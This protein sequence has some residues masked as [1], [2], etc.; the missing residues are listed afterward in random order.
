M[1]KMANFLNRKVLNP[2]KAHLWEESVLLFVCPVSM[3]IM[4]CGR[5][6]KGY[7]IKLPTE[8]LKKIVPALKWGMFFLKA[9]LASQGLG[10][11]A[12]D[13]A[14]LLPIIDDDYI[15]NIEKAIVSCVQPDLEKNIDSLN[16]FDQIFNEILDSTTDEQDQAAFTFLADFLMK[17]EKYQGTNI[18]EWEPKYT[19]LHKAVSDFDGSCMCLDKNSS[20]EDSRL[21]R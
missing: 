18:Q 14:S 1:S 4:K 11:V 17:K 3:K 9:G 6:D 19:G 21:F 8:N 13:L 15:A 12:P 20:K 2:F 16:N 10:F 7:N 5:K